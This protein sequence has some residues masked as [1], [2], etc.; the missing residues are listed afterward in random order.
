MKNKETK[1][2]CRIGNDLFFHLPKAKKFLKVKIKDP[3]K[4]AV[5]WDII[6]DENYKSLCFK[7]STRNHK[8]LRKKRTKILIREMRALIY[9]KLGSLLEGVTKK[10]F[11][12]F[13]KRFIK[14]EKVWD[15]PA[16]WQEERKLYLV[17]CFESLLVG[18]A[19]KRKVS[20]K[21][22]SLK[23]KKE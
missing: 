19:K 1:L 5:S 9:R 13:A 3:K 20:A 10:Q 11:K 12:L 6:S 2:S 7:A 8:K 23:Q 4:L 15:I 22:L 21:L 16:D 17:R 14:S 18:N